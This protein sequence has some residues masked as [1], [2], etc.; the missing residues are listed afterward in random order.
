MACSA[1]PAETKRA[2]REKKEAHITLKHTL[3]KGSQKEFFN[4][5]WE[6]LHNS[7]MPNTA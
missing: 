2:L 5:V 3:P 6:R 7:T 1:C 4:S